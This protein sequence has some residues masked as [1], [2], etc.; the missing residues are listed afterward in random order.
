MSLPH[1]A[2][3][4]PIF[5]AQ[6]SPVCPGR[7]G[8]QKPYCEKQWCSKPVSR[9]EATRWGRL[10][11]ADRGER[12][13]PLHKQGSA[14]PPS[15]DSPRKSTEQ[16]HWG[17][18]S[19]NTTHHIPPKQTSR[20]TQIFQLLPWE[21]G[22]KWI[23]VAWPLPSP[24]RAVL[25]LGKRGSSVELSQ[26]SLISWR[27]ASMDVDTNDGGAQRQFSP[28]TWRLFAIHLSIK[29]SHSFSHIINQMNKHTW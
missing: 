7:T 5:P 13:V 10:Q 29:S 23:S 18:A 22:R 21:G 16:R 20:A 11:W 2:V 17:Q 9:G 27:P 14:W 3:L 28:A 19:K 12:E 6:R 8:S 26:L 25:T 1:R 24:S 4:G 15:L